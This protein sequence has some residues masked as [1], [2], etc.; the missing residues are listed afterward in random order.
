MADCFIVRRGGTDVSD[1][2]AIESLVAAGATF[3]SGEDNELRTGTA[4]INNPV[5][6]VLLAG[7]SYEVPLGHHTGK[8]SISAKDLASQTPGT[9]DGSVIL[10]GYES[11]TNGVKRVG[12]VPIN[13]AVSAALNAGDV[14]WVPAGHHNGNGRVTANSLASQTAGTAA[15]SHILS[16]KTAWVGG[17]K[18]T[19][20]MT[21]RGNATAS[22][23]AGGSYTIPAGYHAGSGK[24]TANSLASQTSANAS[25][26]RI[27]SGYTAWVNG[28][29]ITGNA[30]VRNYIVTTAYWQ[31]NGTLGFT[32]GFSASMAS[33]RANSGGFWY[34]VALD[35]WDMNLC[36][37]VKAGHA[38]VQQ[39]AYREASAVYFSPFG[40]GVADKVNYAAVAAG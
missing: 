12:T 13:G 30:A 17:S 16:G 35:P 1:A 29:K 15:A 3:Y 36:T 39:R 14:Y 11:W 24:V 27:H 5:T 25:A 26:G 21:N 31:G 32:T 6:K 22:L 18:L 2:N 10:S 20:T 40:D 23:N 34:Y 28:A 4:P 19:G 37:W 38:G 7:E 9:A 33:C 8:S